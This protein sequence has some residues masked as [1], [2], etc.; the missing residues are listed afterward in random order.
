MWYSH[1]SSWRMGKFNSQFMSRSILFWQPWHHRSVSSI[2][3]TYSLS[4]TIP[5]HHISWQVSQT[6][7]KLLQICTDSEKIPHHLKP[8]LLDKTKIL[9]EIPHSYELLLNSSSKSE[10]TVEK[11]QESSK[12]EIHTQGNCTL[13]QLKSPSIT[14]NSNS[15]K[16][17]NLLLFDHKL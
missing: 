7:F 9:V 17:I 6:N 3:W 8:S 12:I 4:R 13:S 2:S 5:Y 1:F 11:L 14:V 15:G 16:H 10:V